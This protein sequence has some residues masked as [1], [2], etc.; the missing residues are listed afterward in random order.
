MPVLPAQDGLAAHRD[1]LAR[2]A[3]AGVGHQ[4]QHRGACGGVVVHHLAPRKVRAG[5]LRIIQLA[6]GFHPALARG[7]LQTQKHHCHL[8][9]VHSRQHFHADALVLAD[10]VDGL[11][12]LQRFSPQNGK[13]LA[14]LRRSGQHP[15]SNRKGHGKC[16][17]HGQHAAQRAR[18]APGRRHRH[19]RPALGQDSLLLGG[20][21]LDAAEAAVD[22]GADGFVTN[23]HTALLPNVFAALRAHGE[24]GCSRSTGA[25]PEPLRSHSPGAAGNNA[26]EPLPDIWAS[27]P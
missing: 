18:G 10:L 27:E 24:A 17:R 14:Q 23:L 4:A 13:A 16:R 25:P 19:S 1:L 8:A 22:S 3:L 20:I 9:V 11:Q 2:H 5:Y 12:L 26:A 21:Q 15:A 7:V 6:G